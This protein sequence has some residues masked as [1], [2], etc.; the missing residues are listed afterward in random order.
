MRL[1]L[2]EKNP[3]DLENP[4]K[5][6]ISVNYNESLK[7]IILKLNE[8]RDPEKQITRIYNQYGQQIPDCYQVRGDLTVYYTF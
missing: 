6:D 2:K 3:K 7:E 4:I 8:D 1:I 5:L